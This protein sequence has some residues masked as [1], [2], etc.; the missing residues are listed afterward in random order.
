MV[1]PYFVDGLIWPGDAY[2]E[3]VIFVE[4]MEF[5]IRVQILDEFACISLCVKQHKKDVDLCFSV[6]CY[7]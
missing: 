1:T 7:E 5:A 3:T 4:N 6:T 2:S